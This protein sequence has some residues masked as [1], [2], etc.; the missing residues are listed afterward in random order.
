MILKSALEDFGFG[1]SGGCRGTLVNKVLLDQLL[2][3][4]KNQHTLSIVDWERTEWVKAWIF[5]LTG[6]L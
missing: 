1:V 3:L 5:R 4:L 2:Q 6:S